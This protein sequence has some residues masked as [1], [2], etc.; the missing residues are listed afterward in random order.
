MAVMLGEKRRVQDV[1][2]A[3]LAQNCELRESKIRLITADGEVN[4]RF[5][6]NRN[7]GGRFDISDYE[8]D[9]FMVESEW[10]AAER[11]LSITLPSTC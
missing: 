4:I 11:R 2:D 5:L 1:I 10:R 7:T 9:D 6:H 3:A 8:N